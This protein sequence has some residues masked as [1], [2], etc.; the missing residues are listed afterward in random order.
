MRCVGCVV[1]VG[2]VGCVNKLAKCHRC[3]DNY[4][5]DDNFHVTWSKN[6]RV[7]TA[8]NMVTLAEE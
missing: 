8:M 1:C 3:D 7:F 5:R 2:C 4:R 6:I